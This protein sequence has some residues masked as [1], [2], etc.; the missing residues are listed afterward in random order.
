MRLINSKEKCHILF[1]SLNITKRIMK[2]S[3]PVQAMIDI[4]LN[5]VKIP[6][7]TPNFRLKS[8]TIN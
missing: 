5:M 2:A 7:I 4:S 3:R 8:M 6:R 1:R